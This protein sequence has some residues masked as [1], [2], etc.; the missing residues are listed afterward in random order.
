MQV[1][2][3]RA[4][5]PE[6]AAEV[7]GVHIRSWQVA[8]RGLLPD[9]YLDDLRPE[10]RM[11]HYTFGGADPC[12][13][14]TIVAVEEG[15]ICGFATT[16]PSQDADI[17]DAGQI[18]ALYVDPQAWGLGVGRRLMAEA[19]KHLGQRFADALLWVLVGNDRAERFY[20]VDGWQPDDRRRSEEMWG[21]L[22]HEVRYRRRLP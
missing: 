21:V 11:V 15:V 4:A 22:V 8:Y 20:S 6:D 13:P 12:L 17:P 5:R 18:L 19:R 2:N 9:Q 10:D 1:L 14:A 3:V 16:G 7:A